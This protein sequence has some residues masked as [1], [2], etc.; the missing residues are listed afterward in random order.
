MKTRLNYILK[1]FIFLFFLTAVVNVYLVWAVFSNTGSNRNTSMSNL[2]NL[3]RGV[4][5]GI[6]VPG[7]V[8][9]ILL[10]LLYPRLMISV[11]DAATYLLGGIW[12]TISH[13]RG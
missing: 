3:V 12:R 2:F 1:Y 4:S 7:A 13:R 8:S 5:L 10:I 9:G 6:L 11:L